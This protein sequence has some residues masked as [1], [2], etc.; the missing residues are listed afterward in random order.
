M[1]KCFVF[2]F[3]SFCI[4]LNCVGCGTEKEVNEMNEKESNMPET[5]GH[6]VD[7]Y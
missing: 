5:S 2:L 6:E 7:S 4:L 1:K 3:L